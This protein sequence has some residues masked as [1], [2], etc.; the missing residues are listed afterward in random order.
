MYIKTYDVLCFLKCCKSRIL[1]E[2]FWNEKS[3]SNKVLE[4]FPGLP[5]PPLCQIGLNASSP[6]TLKTLLTAVDIK[7]MIFLFLAK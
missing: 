7:T 3:G 6:Y 1:A 2:T 4:L 5:P